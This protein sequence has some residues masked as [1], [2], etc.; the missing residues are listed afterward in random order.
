[1]SLI[2]SSDASTKDVLNF[3]VLGLTQMILSAL[4]DLIGLLLTCFKAV[5][6]RRWLEAAGLRTSYAELL[7]QEG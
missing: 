7:L 2:Y 3:G 1:M 5:E 4:P 6:M